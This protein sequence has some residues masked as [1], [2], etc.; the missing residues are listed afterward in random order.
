M[1]KISDEGELERCIDTMLNEIRRMAKYR[2]PAFG[3]FE[4]ISYSADNPV[5]GIYADKFT[6]RMVH[7]E[8]EHRKIFKDRYDTMRLL[9]AAVNS[10]KGQISQTIKAGTNDEIVRLPEDF[11]INRIV[12]DTFKDLACNSINY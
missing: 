2:M 4:E 6:L 10:P 9:V 1:N 5:K 8:E 12:L 3:R 11:D 7:P